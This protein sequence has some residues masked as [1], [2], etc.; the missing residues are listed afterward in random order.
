MKDISQ[1]AMELMEAAWTPPNPIRLLGVT[2]IN[3]T[4]APET[5]E[6]MDLLSG[7]KTKQNEKQEKVEKTMDA[8]RARFG[9]AAISYG[10]AKNLDKDDSV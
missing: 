10:T 3:L 6:Q 8:I 7:S 5:Y 4:E 2:A 9:S 1:A